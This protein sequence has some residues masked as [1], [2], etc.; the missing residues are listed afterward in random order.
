MTLEEFAKAIPKEDLIKWYSLPRWRQELIAEQIE[1]IVHEDEKR[2]Y[3]IR[4]SNFN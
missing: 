4:H 1:R 3:F 2:N